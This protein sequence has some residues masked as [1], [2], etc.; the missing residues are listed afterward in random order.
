MAKIG[1]LAMLIVMGLPLAARAEDAWD[2]ATQNDSTP[3]TA[4]AFLHGT[5][6]THDLQASGT[7]DVDYFRIVVR[8]RQSFEARVYGGSVFFNAFPGA[9][10]AGFC[11]RLDRTDLNGI[12]VQQAAQIEGDDNTIA[13]RWTA[14]AD[15]TD[16]VR[17]RGP[18]NAN[19]FDQYQ[20]TMLNTTLFAPRFN[21]TSSQTSIL[22]LQNVTSASATGSVDFWAANG[23]LLH[24]EP[25]T[26]T[27]RGVLVLN[28]AGI[29]AVAGKSGSVSISHDAGY[30]G[31]VG[32]LV[33]VEPA[34]GF[35][36]DTAVTPL[37][38]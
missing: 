16:F 20:I 21:N 38:R 19:T 7:P 1:M 10:Q 3:A 18:N 25:F 27:A 15:E 23:T 17:V 8:A 31:L 36:F 32:K 30:A 33:S 4:N 22:Q 11:A 9:C 26:I 14:S 2:Q 6:Q 12:V 35:T 28:S 37:P 24:G 13:V 29:A 34:T 5:V